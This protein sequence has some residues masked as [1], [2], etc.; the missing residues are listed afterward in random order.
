MPDLLAAHK[1]SDFF[2]NFQG[3]S[4]LEND[5]LGCNFLCEQYPLVLQFSFFGFNLK[6]RYLRYCSFLQVK[7]K[8]VFKMFIL[9]SISLLLIWFCFVSSLNSHRKLLELSKSGQERVRITSN[10]MEK[11]K[12][13]QQCSH[14]FLQE[15]YLFFEQNCI[16]P[17]HICIDIFHASSIRQLLT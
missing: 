7:V 4:L 9:R 3:T 2:F 17:F 14:P 6:Q 5:I 12:K 8:C 11:W 15:F 13:L 1:E 10:E 16:N